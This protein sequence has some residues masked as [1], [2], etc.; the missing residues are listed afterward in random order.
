[1]G[2]RPVTNRHFHLTHPHATPPRFFTLQMNFRN[3]F[4][5]KRL[6]QGRRE[7]AASAD[8][9]LQFQSSEGHFKESC[10]FGGPEKGSGKDV[11]EAEIHQ[12]NRPKETCHQLGTKGIT[13]WEI[14]QQHSSPRWGENSPKP[15]E[16]LIQESSQAL[17]PK[18]N[19]LQGALY[20]CSEEEVGDKGVLTAAV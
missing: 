6:G 2:D 4:T 7:C 12:Q 17:P 18:E 14:S 15:A 10:V 19:S 20:L 3:H 13:V 16:R 11:S 9:G 8:T 5:W 1:M